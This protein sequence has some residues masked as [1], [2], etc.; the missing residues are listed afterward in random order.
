MRGSSYKVISAQGLVLLELSGDCHQP[1][2]AKLDHHSH[3]LQGH[4]LPTLCRGKL[5]AQSEAA[6]ATYNGRWHEDHAR[7]WGKSQ[8]G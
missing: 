2:Q 1:I 6:L 3:I 8:P 5:L 7:T 4:G